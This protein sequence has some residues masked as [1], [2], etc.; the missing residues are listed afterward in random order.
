MFSPQEF[1]RITQSPE[2]SELGSQIHYEQ[3]C[4]A[5]NKFHL[6]HEPEMHRYRF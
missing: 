3:L 2:H 4:A 1:E 5:W 6:L